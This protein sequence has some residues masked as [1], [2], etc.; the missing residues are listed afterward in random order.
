MVIVICYQTTFKL[1]LQEEFIQN[2][3]EQNGAKTKSVKPKPLR[4]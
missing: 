2:Q 4:T 3:H 1:N